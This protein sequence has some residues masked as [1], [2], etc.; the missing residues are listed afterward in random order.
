MRGQNL[1]D[2]V[3]VLDEITN[4]PRYE[5][6]T[7]LTRMGQNVKCFCTG[8][9]RQ[10]D[11]NHLNSENNGLTWIIKYLTGYENYGHVTLKGRKTRGP[12]CDIVRKSGL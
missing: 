8:D 7:M 1:E 5:V 12:I 9:T 2:C 6:R 10:I 3:V 4:F 11:N